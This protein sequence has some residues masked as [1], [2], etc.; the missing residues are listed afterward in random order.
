MRVAGNFEKDPLVFARER[1]DEQAGDEL[2]Q[3][4][5]D[6]GADCGNQEAFSEQLADE[7]RTGCAERQAHRDLALA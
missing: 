2:R 1:C 5:A 7:T 3:E 4:G 6:A